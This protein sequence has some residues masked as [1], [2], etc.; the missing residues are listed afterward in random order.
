MSNIVALRDSSWVFMSCHVIENLF[1]QG[2]RLAFNAQPLEANAIPG[3][4]STNI[5]KVTG[6]LACQANWRT[7]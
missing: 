3:L 4:L 1:P 2:N 7:F 5:V 6:E